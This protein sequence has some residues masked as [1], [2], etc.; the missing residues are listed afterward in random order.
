MHSV[1]V[2]EWGLTHIKSG[3]YV[4]GIRKDLGYYDTLEGFLGTHRPDKEIPLDY[5]RL[6]TC[7]NKCTLLFETGSDS[8]F[9]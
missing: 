3:N 5:E 1:S 7:E 9:V 8:L 6:L 2:K 4:R